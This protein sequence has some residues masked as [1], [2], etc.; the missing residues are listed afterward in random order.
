MFA[1]EN[2]L[3]DAKKLKVF[4]NKFSKLTQHLR[5]GTGHWLVVSTGIQGAEPSYITKMA[6]SYE[7]KQ[8]RVEYIL[9]HTYD[10][11]EG[12]Q[13][14]I[15]QM[16]EAIIQA[17]NGCNKFVNVDVNFTTIDSLSLSLILFIAQYIEWV[18]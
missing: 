17:P 15:L 14:P 6:H 10:G 4:K 18:G 8:S 11:Y 7:E 13:T 9:L 12:N 2:S 3:S 5:D 1:T 16:A